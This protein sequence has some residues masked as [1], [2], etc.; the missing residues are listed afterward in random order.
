MIEY[1][2]INMTKPRISRLLN[3]NDTRNTGH[4]QEAD[5][6]MFWNLNLQYNKHSSSSAPCLHSSPIIRISTMRWLFIGRH[7]IGWARIG[8]NQRCSCRWLLPCSAQLSSVSFYC[9]TTSPAG[10]PTEESL[11][12]TAVCPR[13]VK[14]GGSWYKGWLPSDSPR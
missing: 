4:K 12:C 3:W 13:A 5:E 2:Y 9:S 14:L 11:A 7:A 10:V 1:T 8:P 6:W